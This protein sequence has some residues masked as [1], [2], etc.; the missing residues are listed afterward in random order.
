MEMGE[1]M[2][3]L[4]VDDNALFLASAQRFLSNVAAVE[5]VATARDGI[6]ALEYLGHDRPDLVVM[7][8]N[9]PRMNG[10][11]ATRRIKALDPT[12]RV[13]VVSLHDAAE[14]RTAAALA[15]AESFITKQ[16]FAAQLP[17]LLTSFHVGTEPAAE[18][19][20]GLKRA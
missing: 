7:D 20:P 3:I 11:E 12:L 15:G 6:E 2:K 13:V 5:A 8:L 14:F 4:L 16:D 18:P 17:G 19:A 1:G 9:M 10:F